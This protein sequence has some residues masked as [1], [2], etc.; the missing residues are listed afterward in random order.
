MIFAEKHLYKKIIILIAIF[1][2]LL[3]A[4]S[5]FTN[6]KLKQKTADLVN[7]IVF[8]YNGDTYILDFQKMRFVNPLI[9]ISRETSLSAVDI[10]IFKNDILVDNFYILFEVKGG[11]MLYTTGYAGLKHESIYIRMV[12][13]LTETWYADDFYNNSLPVDSIS[14]TNLFSKVPRTK[15]SRFCIDFYYMEALNLDDGVLKPDSIARYLASYT[16][17]FEKDL[18]YYFTEYNK[19]KSLSESKIIFDVKSFLP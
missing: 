19:A 3:C 13:K 14:K 9:F 6:Y 11:P 15:S 4:F 2:L 18:L 8:E 17:G 16:S 7:S 12:D 5:I 10:N 1:L